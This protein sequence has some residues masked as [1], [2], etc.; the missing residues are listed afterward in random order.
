MTWDAVPGQSWLLK[1]RRISAFMKKISSYS[2]SDIWAGPGLGWEPREPDPG[3]DSELMLGLAIPPRN[4]TARMIGRDL[5]V[6][7]DRTSAR[8]TR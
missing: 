2:D 5:Q 7:V 1:L 6:E 8:G 4:V 3:P